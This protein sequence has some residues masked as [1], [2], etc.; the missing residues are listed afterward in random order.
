MRAAD[1]H[2]RLRLHV[3]T[4]SA[5]WSTRGVD[6]VQRMRAGNQAPFDGSRFK[7]G[8]EVAS[9]FIYPVKSDR[10]DVKVAMRWN[11]GAIT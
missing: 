6:G 9:F 5:D 10:A 1:C 8:D 4:T 3:P 2:A 11:T 7:A